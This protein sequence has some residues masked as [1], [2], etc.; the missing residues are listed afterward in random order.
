[1]S[2]RPIGMHTYVFQ[3]DRFLKVGRAEKIERRLRQ[4]QLMCPHE[5]SLVGSVAADVE[6]AAHVALLDAGVRR[7]HG[8][9]FEDTE[10]ARDVLVRLG[11]I[12]GRG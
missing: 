8:E 11:I 10:V 7:I 6:R 2:P 5:V 12:A 4:V 1:M 3:C 9:W